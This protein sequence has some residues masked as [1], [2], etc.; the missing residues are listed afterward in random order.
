MHFSRLALLLFAYD[1]R[2]KGVLGDAD[3]AR[4]RYA[5]K[6]DHLADHMVLGTGDYC[7]LFPS[8]SDTTREV[9]G[10]RQRL[11][12]VMTQMSCRAVE[13]L[14]D[15]SGPGTTIHHS[16]AACGSYAPRQLENDHRR[17]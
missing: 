11:D 13:C 10:L 17:G 1:W 3:M 5:V 9:F 16:Y 4:L 8:Q 6:M 7:G 2:G 14:V 12:L 15:A